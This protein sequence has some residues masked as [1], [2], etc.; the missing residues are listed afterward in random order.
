MKNQVHRRDFLAGMTSLAAYGI[1]NFTFL[2]NLPLLQADEVAA[3]TNRVALA[4]DIEPLVRFLETTP[5]NRIIP[6]TARRIQSGTSYQDLLAALLLAGVR[7]V[8]PRPV[9]FQFHTVL[10]VNSTHLASI[11]AQDRDRWLPLLWAVDNFKTSEE[12]DRR[13]NNWTMPTLDESRIPPGHEAQRRFQSA[14]ENWDVEAAG[15]AGASLVRNFGANQ[16]IELFWRYGVRDFR[17]I[18]HKAIFVANSWRALQTIGWR[19]AEP[20]VRSLTDALLA[21]EGDNP[22]RREDP[23]DM[24]YRENQQRLRRIRENWHRG[25]ASR[26]ATAEML[27]TLRTDT[28]ANCCEQIVEKLNEQVSPN[29]LWDALFLVAG[30]QLMRQPGIVGLHCVTTINA[31]HFAFQTAVNEDTRKLVLLQAAAFMPMFRQAMLDRGRMRD[32]LRI[33][34]LE[35]MDLT[36][37]GNERYE[38]I[39]TDI[40]QDKVRAARKTLAL[41]SE[42]SAPRAESLMDGARRLIFAKG[43]NAHDYKYSSAALEDYYHVSPAWRNRFLAT[44]M[45]QLRGA[46]DRDNALI[47]QARQ[48]LAT[49]S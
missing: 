20:V 30:E 13:E 46:Q 33:D 44:A 29:S 9:G 2:Q 15:L 22:A 25:R 21:H 49:R 16:V 39:L 11:A 43:T 5:R 32:D 7:N 37:R 34:Q 23:R 1:G 10:A 14:M 12:R 36:A 6:E 48:A 45:F 31:F 18:G 47:N 24:P 26:D 17:D 3:P 19:H 38:E 4:G 8:R 28:P 41:L 27:A 40:S 42:E 35:P